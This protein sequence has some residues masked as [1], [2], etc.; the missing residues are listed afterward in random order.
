MKHFKPLVVQTLASLIQRE[1][2][3]IDDFY[4]DFLQNISYQNPPIIE[5]LKKPEIILPAAKEIITDIRMVNTRILDKIKRDPTAVY[6]LQP[7]EFE[8]LVA[9][10]FREK[11]Y[12]VEL[13]QAT[14]DGGK[15]L[16]I[17]DKSL[18]N[19]LIYAECKKFAPNRPVGVSIISDLAGRIDNDRATAGIV[20]T[21][22]YF[23]QEAKTFTN[24]IQ[25]KM[26]LVDYLKLEDWIKNGL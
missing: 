6:G 5:A 2:F 22:S 3:S 24:K 7:R 17:I 1:G 15:D 26:S 11:G 25:H 18:G 14:R 10:I 23:S 20:I 19:F 12:E 13:T 16:M 4:K 8:K 9:E 21:T